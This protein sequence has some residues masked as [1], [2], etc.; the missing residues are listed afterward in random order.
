MTVNQ[1]LNILVLC[2]TN[3]A[4]DQFCC[5][6]LPLTKRLVRLGGRSKDERLLDYSIRAVARASDSSR[7]LARQLWELGNQI[8]IQIAKLD[9]EACFIGN[10]EPIV[11]DRC[12]YV[13]VCSLHM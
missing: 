11:P 6:L 13:P 2:Y 3:H 5:D 9:T 12:E 8:K 1:G 10:G 4:L 7:N